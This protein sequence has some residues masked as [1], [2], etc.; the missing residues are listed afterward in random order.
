M[1]NSRKYSLYVTYA[2]VVGVLFI[3]LLFPGEKVKDYLAFHLNETHPDLSLSIDRIRPDFPP[4]IRTN[5]VSLY[6]RNSEVLGI[7]WASIAPKLLSLLG[8]KTT[9]AFIGRTLD[10]EFNG[11][12]AI[13]NDKDG[14]R[15]E[16]EGDFDNFQI[17]RIPA[18]Q[19][20]SER[21]MTGRLSGNVIYKGKG[22]LGT[23]RINVTL[24]DGELELTT[25]VLN[26]DSIAFKT[27]EADLVL[28]GERLQ[29]KTCEITGEQMEGN[30]S[31]TIHL[32]KPFKESTIQLR[33][34]LKPQPAFLS[35][36]KK[37]IPEALLPRKLTGRNGFPVTLNGTLEEPAFLLR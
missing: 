5:G 25:P 28:T 7:E 17:S 11:E 4:G 20:F 18:L 3:Y 35:D 16:I 10:G 37:I 33:G 26:L 21:K 30:L 9:Y 34:R 13:L 14:P 12:A 36:I 23:T 24:S 27:L 32:K 6:Y 2:I 29:V 31:G 8:K 19:H 15:F 1:N 22:A